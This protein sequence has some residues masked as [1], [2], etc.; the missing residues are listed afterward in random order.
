MAR[1]RILYW[2][3]IPTGVRAW[4]ANGE[5]RE[6]LPQRFQVA[7]DAVATATG[8]IGTQSYLAGWQ[9]GAVKQQEGSA[10]EVARAIADELVDAFSPDRVKSMRQELERSLLDEPIRARASPRSRDNRPDRR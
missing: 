3:G 5:V 8:R 2:H 4:D 10:R 1:Y 6:S 7:V 9:W